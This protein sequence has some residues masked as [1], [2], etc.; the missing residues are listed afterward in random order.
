M[1]TEDQ[2]PDYEYR[3]RAKKPQYSSLVKRVQAVMIDSAL[4]LVVAF[5]VFSVIDS[6]IID[7]PNIKAIVFFLLFIFYDP[8]MITGA[9]ATAGQSMMSLS[10]RKASNHDE[11]VP[12]VLAVIRFVVKVLLGWVSLLTVTANPEKRAIHDFASDSVVLQAG[13]KKT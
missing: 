3:S 7:A 12:F 8:L 9:G 5:M 6:T 1:E 11:K 10:V 13:R 4:V 2:R